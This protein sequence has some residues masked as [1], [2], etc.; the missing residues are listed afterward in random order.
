MVLLSWR[1]GTGIL[2]FGDVLHLSLV[3]QLTR[4]G[5]QAHGVAAQL[6]G[7]VAIVGQIAHHEVRLLADPVLLDVDRSPEGGGEHYCDLSRIPRAFRMLSA[8]FRESYGIFTRHSG[9]R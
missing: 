5:H 3:D 4:L 2:C 7:Q 1:T 9:G 6:I 8:T